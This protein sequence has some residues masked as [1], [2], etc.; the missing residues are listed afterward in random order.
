MNGQLS[1]EFLFSV[2]IYT[3]FLFVL[4][5]AHKAMNENFTKNQEQRLNL[6]E[7]SILISEQRL[8]NNFLSIPINQGCAVTETEVIC[9]TNENWPGTVDSEEIQVKKYTS[10]VLE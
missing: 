7:T 1:L 4:L 3:S 10:G 5:N 2:L 6:K 9:K 8:N